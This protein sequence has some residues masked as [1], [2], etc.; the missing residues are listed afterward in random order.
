MVVNLAALLLRASAVRRALASL[1]R[2]G[3]RL[4]HTPIESRDQRRESEHRLARYACRLHAAAC[5]CAG[6]CLATP[7]VCPASTGGRLRSSRRH[8]SSARSQPAR[9]RYAP[10]G[11]RSRASSPCAT[12]R[13]RRRPTS[14]PIMKSRRSTACR[15]RARRRCCSNDRSITTA[16][17]TKKSRA[18]SAA[19]AAR[20]SSTPGWT[21]CSSPRSTPTIW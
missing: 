8:S 13:S 12:R 14:S 17:R 20:S 4:G 18:G 2:G 11:N 5:I 15:P 9:E 21:T 6:T 7:P 3:G 10:P 16:A 19:G 1:A